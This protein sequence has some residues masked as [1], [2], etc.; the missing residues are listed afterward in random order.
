MSGASVQR[1]LL[2]SLETGDGE[3][4]RRLI[5]AGADVNLRQQAEKS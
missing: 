4:V 2:R 5:L 3:E 1:Q